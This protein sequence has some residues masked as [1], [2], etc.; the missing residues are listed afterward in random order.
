MKLESM[1]DTSALREWKEFRNTLEELEPGVFLE[2]FRHSFSE[3]LRPEEAN[4]ML[5]QDIRSSE[6]TVSREYLPDDAELPDRKTRR[7]MDTGEGIWT[8]NTEEL[9]EA[10]GMKAKLGI[11]YMEN[12]NGELHLRFRPHRE[13]YENQGIELYA[14]QYD[15]ECGYPSG[16]I[17]RFEDLTGGSAFDGSAPV[18][19]MDARL[20]AS[21]GKY[22][23]E[24]LRKTFFCVLENQRE[25][26]SIPDVSVKRYQKQYWKT[27]RELG[28]S[29]IYG[30]P[31]D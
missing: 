9:L 24:D 17:I 8:H 4:P 11:P 28:L 15:L 20:L 13:E 3:R 18:C 23:L 7:W 6:K 16:N 25:D 5:E 1:T 29:Q 2:H 27:V 10:L 30:Y 22:L 21:E 26:G 19:K 12:Q 31:E 14:Q